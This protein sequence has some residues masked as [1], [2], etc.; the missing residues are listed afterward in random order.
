MLLRAVADGSTRSLRNAWY[1]GRS[2]R[3][4]IALVGIWAETNPNMRLRIHVSWWNSAV[5]KSSAASLE[6]FVSHFCQYGS[7]WMSN[8]IFLSEL[9]I[10]IPRLPGLFRMSTA[11][12]STIELVNS[13]TY[14]SVNLFNFAIWA[15]PSKYFPIE[16]VPC[17]DGW[18]RTWYQTIH[19]IPGLPVSSIPQCK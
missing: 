3:F 13:V 4:D 8:L 15:F 10:G 17:S 9:T 16:L 7:T 6:W 11:V 1:D 18:R 2:S 14:D 19:I 5:S 12:S